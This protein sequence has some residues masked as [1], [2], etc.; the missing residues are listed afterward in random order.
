MG[1]NG[2]KR[3]GAGRKSNAVKLMEAGFVCTYFGA[4]EQE[5]LWKS[6]LNSEDENV[7]LNAAKY[8]SD[9]LYGKAPQM[10]D[11]NH[12]GSIELVKRVV[13]DL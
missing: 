3:P 1:K 2:G 11:L 6:L 10:V 13:S 5:K 7:K 9:R 4:L 12:G 8:L